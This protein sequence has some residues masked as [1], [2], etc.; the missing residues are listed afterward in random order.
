MV[1]MLCPHCGCYANCTRQWTSEPEPYG[2]DPIVGCLTCDHCGKPI[3]V[4]LDGQNMVMEHWPERVWGRD[5]PDVPGPI[6]TT[7]NE[8]HLCLA[9]G[10][11]RGAA[12]LARAVVESVAK[13]KGILKADLKTKIEALHQA[14]HISEAM[15]EAAHEIR[16]VGNEAAHGDLVAEPL[17]LANADEIVSLMD[18]IL[19]RVYQ[20]PARVARIRRKRE[21]RQRR[22]EAM[23]VFDDPPF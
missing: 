17:S 16:F 19:E 15:R 14:G 20:E 3:A 5:F 10:S 23:A 9:A 7:A 12:A 22:Q 21:E 13:N 6:A 11:A 18:S 8:A 1:A 2:F 4:V